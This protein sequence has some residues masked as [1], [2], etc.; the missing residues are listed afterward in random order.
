MYF[1]RDGPGRS[2]ISADCAFSRG[3]APLFARAD[4]GGA[5][6]HPA[7]ARLGCQPGRIQTR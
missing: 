5:D 4:T 1:A 7:G 2:P 6:G 3:Y